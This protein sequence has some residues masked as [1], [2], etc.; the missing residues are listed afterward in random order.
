MDHRLGFVRLLL[1]VCSAST[2]LARI[3]SSQL[4][5]AD[6]KLERAS[7]LC[8]C[9]RRVS[10]STAS[11]GGADGTSVLLPLLV[12]A[13]WSRS[14]GRVAFFA[15]CKRNDDEDAEM[16]RPVCKPPIG[17]NFRQ[18]IAAPLSLVSAC[19]VVSFYLREWKVSKCGA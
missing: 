11:G 10:S 8:A 1:C 17:G 6:S 3:G 9:G 19:E 2:Y 4:E 14:T 12:S 13:C 5:D 18:A 7:A 15:L 16:D